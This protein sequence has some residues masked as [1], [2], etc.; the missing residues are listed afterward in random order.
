MLSVLDGEDIVAEGGSSGT[1]RT[2]PGRIE[3]VLVMLAAQSVRPL[4]L[5]VGKG[6]KM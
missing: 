3:L 1:Q 4:E 5:C 2:S 6:A